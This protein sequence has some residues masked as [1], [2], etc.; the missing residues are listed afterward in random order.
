MYL[1]EMLPYY[2]AT[3]HN[4]YTKSVRWFL[5]EME[6]LP[7]QLKQQFEDGYFVDRR[8][9][10]YCSGISTDYAIETTLMGGTGM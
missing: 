7:Q 1:E 9:E 10:Y 5:Q 6:E 2:A 3:G 8:T 4:N